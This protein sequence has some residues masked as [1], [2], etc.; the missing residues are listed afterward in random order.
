MKSLT[1]DITYSKLSV[2]MSVFGKKQS[3]KFVKSDIQGLAD[4]IR[5]KTMIF[6]YFFGTISVP[7]FVT[8][9]DVYSVALMIVLVCLL[10]FAFK[11]KHCLMNPKP[12]V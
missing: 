10:L 6:A 7:S 12:V 8:N 11:R 1:L 9:R 3:I 5:L 4:A 2:D